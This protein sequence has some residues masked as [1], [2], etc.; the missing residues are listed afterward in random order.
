MEVFS[1][2]SSNP[3]FT[4]LVPQITNSDDFGAFGKY[5]VSFFAQTGKTYYILVDGRTANS[6]ENTGNFQL[7]MSFN[8]L[9]HSTRLSAQN[10]RTGISVFRPSNGSWYTDLNQFGTTVAKQFGSS[11]DVP[12][13]ADYNGDGV[14][15]YAVIRTEAGKTVWYISNLNFGFYAVQWGLASDRV[16][17]GDYDRDGAADLI[18]IRPTAQ[19][20]VWYIR[21]SSDKSLRTF[22]FG[23][24]T[25]KPIAGDIDGD[26]QTDLMV[27]RQTANGNLEWHIMRS[28]VFEGGFPYTKYN[29]I[30]FG[31]SSD[32]PVVEDFDGDGKTDLSV[33]RPSNGTW[34][35]LR[36][37]TNQVSGIAYGSNGDIPQA[38]DYDGDGKADVAVFRPSL[39]N[40]YFQYSGTDTQS[41]LHWG[42]SSD[43]P[44]SS[45]YLF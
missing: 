9:G 4:Q 7:Q 38:S 37:K 5:P 35:T 1:T 11:T 42:I 20:L 27:L 25:D 26:G 22:N 40:W 44:V 16:L 15:D 17:T 36:S 21:L 13:P 8:K 41:A 29:G 6:G 19:G 32:I 28:G 39:G 3:T 43:I 45:A 31:L 33:F 23:I 34:Y 24:N 10:P 14:T 2:T 12:I 18:A 30:Q